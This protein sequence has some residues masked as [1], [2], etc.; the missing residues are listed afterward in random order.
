MTQ[1]TATSAQADSVRV[2]ALPV[3]MGDAVTADVRPVVSRRTP[4]HRVRPVRAM[5]PGENV[6]A[7]MVMRPA[8]IVPDATV[9]HPAAVVPIARI[10]PVATV[11]DVRPAP[12]VPEDA[13]AV[14]E[15]VAAPRAM[16]SVACG[17]P[18]ALPHAA[19]GMR[20]NG[21]L[22]RIATPSARAPF[23]HTTMTR[24]S[25]RASKP[26]SWIGWLAMNSKP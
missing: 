7:A 20:A 14:P 17:P 25:Q 6:L 8:R 26:A 18:V 5:L 21:R 15:T 22:P 13:M 4:A 12:L 16:A 10:V 3:T 24:S 11:T 19:T 2:A 9:M 23:A 1:E